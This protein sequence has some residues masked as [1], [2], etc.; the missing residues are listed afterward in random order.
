MRY[1]N[2]IE[3]VR[4]STAR[5]EDRRGIRDVGS[6]CWDA[7]TGRLIWSD[8]HLAMFGLGL[9]CEPVHIAALQ[10]RI[11]P[12]DRSRV[13]RAI[14]RALQNTRPFECTYRVLLPDGQLRYLLTV[15][16]PVAHEATSTRYVGITND[17]TI[18]RKANLQRRQSE[19]RF[20]SLAENSPDSIVRYNHACERIYVNPS[21]ERHTG[22]SAGQMLNSPLELNWQADISAAR[23]RELLQQVL[24]TGIEKQVCCIWAAR[25]RAPIYYAVHLVAEKAADGRIVS[26]LAIGRNVT[27]LKL[28]EHKLEES[29]LVI[30][31]LARHSEAV[32]DDERKRVAR[33]LHDDLAQSLHALRLHILVVDQEH[34]E[35][36]PVLRE[37]TNVLISLVESAIDSVRTAILNLR[38]G[39]LDAGISSA[40]ASLVHQ[41]TAETGVLCDYKNNL[42][43]IALREDAKTAVF[44]IIQEAL[45][46]VARHSRAQRAE[47]D[48][49]QNGVFL[50]LEVRDN[51]VGFIFPSKVHASFGLVGIRDRVLMFDGSFD[52]TTAPSQGTLLSIRIPM[53][54]IQS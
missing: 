53:C 48:I 40:L 23:Y 12:V 32:R 17:I 46:N 19:E 11:H 28:I 2:I 30:Q 54:E 8:E 29:R 39:A 37:N 13:L 42:P 47:I 38:P 34:G 43:N 27:T 36:F 5:P 26:A 45:R 31:R 18:R 1:Q 35:Q 24:E 21:H 15:G 49:Y 7:E 22:L 3:R 16:Y 33:N 14:L 10:E 41:F 25:E 9:D 50:V 6:W 4:P 51:G 44:K 52:L 20:R